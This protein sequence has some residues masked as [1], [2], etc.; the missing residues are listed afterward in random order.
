M[1]KLLWV[2]LCSDKTVRAP[3]NSSMHSLQVGITE[4]YIMPCNISFA[5]MSAVNGKSYKASNVLELWIHTRLRHRKFPCCEASGENL[6]YMFAAY[7]VCSTTY[8]LQYALQSIFLHSEL[9]I[10]FHFAHTVS[11][12]LKE[13]GWREFLVQGLDFRITTVRNATIL[14]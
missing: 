5:A 2:R 12:Q 13:Q 6:F 11:T 4:A 9:K 10:V 3:T 1:G 14:W 8:S 7:P